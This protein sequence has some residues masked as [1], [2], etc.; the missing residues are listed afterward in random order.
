MLRGKRAF[1]ARAAP[2]GLGLR[3]AGSVVCTV[4]A[5]VLALAFLWVLLSGLRPS[6]EDQ[7]VSRYLI[8]RHHLGAL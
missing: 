2:A 6:A 8:G 7:C 4:L 5:A 1:W 3:G